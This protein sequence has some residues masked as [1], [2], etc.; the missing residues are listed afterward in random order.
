MDA[1]KPCPDH[2]N[3]YCYSCLLATA[4]R[5][6]DEAAANHHPFQH[7]LIRDEKRCPTCCLLASPDVQALGP[8]EATK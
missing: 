7:D 3:V 2:D 5:L 8:T 4:R 6:R 1:S